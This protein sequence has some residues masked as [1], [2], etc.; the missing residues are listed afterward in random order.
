MHSFGEKWLKKTGKNDQQIQRTK[1]SRGGG[2][3]AS[4]G[5]HSSE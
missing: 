2:M 1:A 4:F 3:A 5:S